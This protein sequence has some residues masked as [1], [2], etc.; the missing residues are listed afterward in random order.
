MHT[1]AGDVQERTFDVYSQDTR[2]ASRNGGLHCG[3]RARHDIEISADERGKKSDRAEAP[4]RL[5]DGLNRSN[6]RC[7]VEEYA[8]AAVDL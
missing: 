5:A 2:N 8:A 4:V 1:L 3:D 6:T 7:I